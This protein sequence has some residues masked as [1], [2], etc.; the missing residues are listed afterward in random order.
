MEGDKCTFKF[1]MA[2]ETEE[3]ARTYCEEYVPYHIITAVP[4]S[5][6]TECRAEATLICHSGWVQMFGRCYR[7][8]KQMM[9][10][11]EGKQ[12]CEKERK[13]SKIG[14]MHREALPFRI[15]EYYTAV[16]QYWIDASEAITG[17]LIYDVPDGNLLIAND[18]Y[19]YSLP[20]IALARVDKSTK[21]MV[22]CEYTPE[23]T[24]SESNWLLEKYGQIYYP[25]VRTSEGSYVRTASSLN[26]NENDNTA[27]N[28]Y[29]ERVM[30]PFVPGGMAQSAF[31]TR[32]FMNKVKEVNKNDRSLIVRTSAFSKNSQKAERQNKRCVSRAAA[33]FHMIVT[34]P[35][36]GSIA[37]T[38]EQSS[39]KYSKR[40]EVCD[41]ATWSSA[42]VLS[43]EGSPGLELMS[44]AR[45]APIYCQS[46][47]NTYRYGPCPSG[48]AQY[49]R[50]ST[51]QR[52]CHKF[53]KS[54]KNYDS[55]EDNCQTMG[56]HLS[57]FT[58]GEEVDFLDKL[59][60]GASLD[61]W[62]GAK[63]RKQCMKKGSFLEDGFDRDVTS[64]CSRVRVF[65]WLNEVAPNPPAVEDDYWRTPTEPNYIAEGEDCLSIVPGSPRRQLNENAC[66]R[67]FYSFC[68]LEAPIVKV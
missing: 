59:M 64:P 9:T 58:E 47:T 51:G 25:T 15:A 61:T 12:R 31:P 1:P 5:P 65:E 20:N 63:R 14:F 41:A 68:G 16:Y 19:P 42:I 2:T 10:K 30:R 43:H 18:G 46:I 11:D 60:A 38:V 37:K 33:D 36:G 44:D 7:M 53:V 35:S 45:Y 4:G 55:A 57:A 52:W 29:C 49:D 22:L 17:N 50:K 6:T 39:W 62:I 32:E 34:K 3:S 26:R 8:V 27:D 13:G 67:R 23:M 48:F 40:Q 56:A 66:P 28:K 54:S 24:Q 21:A